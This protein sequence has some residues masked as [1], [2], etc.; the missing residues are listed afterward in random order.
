MDHTHRSWRLGTRLA[1]AGRAQGAG[2]AEPLVQPLYQSTV[3]AF[4]SVAQVDAVYDRQAAGHVYYRMGTPNTAALESAVASAEGGEAAVAAASGMGA[5]TAVVL[6]LAGQGDH[7]VADRHAYGGTFGL[8]T[9]ELPRLGLD[10]AL[11]DA[12]DLTAVEAALRPNTRALL[13]ET[14][15]NPTLRVGDIPRL[16]ALGRARGIPVVVDN[17]FTTPVLVRPLDLG[18]DV[19]VHSLAK[20]LGGHSAGMGGIAVGRAALIEAAR[21]KVVHFGSSL[22][23]FDAWMVGQGLPTLALRVR[24]HSQNALIV[25]RFLSEQPAVGRV[26]YPGL[27]SHPGHALASRLFSGGFGGMVAFSLKGGRPAVECFVNGLD[28]VAFAPSLADVTTTISYP[29]AT[30]HRGLSAATLAAMDIDDGMLRLSVG[31][32]DVGDIVADLATALKSAT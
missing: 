1:R 7:V 29:V 9:Q 8:L 27:P 10:T 14:L 31:I 18:A 21:S 30:S 20:Y 22:G 24:A 32:E 17:T 4:E 13:V 26:L 19:V 23:S 5:I 6:A 28:L 15:T 25:A 3:F 12:D 2:A 16:A 11:V